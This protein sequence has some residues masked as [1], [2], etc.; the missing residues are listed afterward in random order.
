MR[1]PGCYVPP[2]PP[3]QAMVNQI[4]AKKILVEN[5]K[6]GNL[7]NEFIEERRKF[8]QNFCRKMTE[9]PHLFYSEEF[10]LFLRSSTDNIEK[11]I[12]GLLKQSYDDILQ[13]YQVA[14]KMLSGVSFIVLKLC[15]FTE[16]N[17]ERN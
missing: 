3:K 4:I 17:L 10:K 8:L 7:D 6:Q 15:L 16:K 14:F 12:T 13:K 1:W 5:K 9:L 11:L 2:L